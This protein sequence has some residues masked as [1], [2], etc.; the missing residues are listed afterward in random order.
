[1]IKLADLIVKSIGEVSD[2][3]EKYIE[4]MESLGVDK[5]NTFHP[6]NFL[7]VDELEAAAK[8]FEKLSQ[9]KARRD[10]D[11]IEEHI[12][13]SGSKYCLKSK[14]TG[15]NLGCYPSKSGAKKRE[16]QVQYFKHKG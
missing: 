15:R 5:E 12:V 11:N 14:K 3:I 10:P 2:S 9:L 7:R 6:K 13:K 1:M 16:R 8:R 4:Y